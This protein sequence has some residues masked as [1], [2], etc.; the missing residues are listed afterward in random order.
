MR[1]DDAAWTAR[2]RGRATGEKVLLSLGLVAVAASSPARVVSV[3][4]LVVALLVAVLARV[5]AR[6]YLTAVAAPVGFVA[7][8]ALAMTVRWPR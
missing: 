7:V 5:P 1:L 4:V 6:T 2:W 3:V 8:S